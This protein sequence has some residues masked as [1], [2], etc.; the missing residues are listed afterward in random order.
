MVLQVSNYCAASLH[1][2][3]VEEWERENNDVNGSSQKWEH[4]LSRAFTRA[5]DALEDG[6]VAP[7]TVGSTALVVIVSAC[8]IIVS[9]CG[10][11]RAVLCRGNAIL[12]LTRDHKPNRSDEVER[13]KNGGGRIIFFQGERVEGMLALTRSIGD[14][15]L[16]QWVTSEPELTFIPRCAEDE[17]LILASDGLWDKLS[18]IDVG[19]LVRKVIKKKRK[20]AIVNGDFSLLTRSVTSTLLR[21]ARK[22]GSGDNISVIAV[23]LASQFHQSCQ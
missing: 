10:D 13:I 4:V 12:S 20:Q 1:N 2:F 9:N 17:F 22:R 15:Y 7:R 11:C 18:T 16:K 6:I 19:K 5:D 14:H 21:A 8:Q 23:D 3:V